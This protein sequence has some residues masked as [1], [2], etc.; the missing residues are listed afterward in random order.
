MPMISKIR[1]VKAKDDLKSS[2]SG[3]INF[4]AT[5]LYFKDLNWYMMIE[6]NNEKV[7]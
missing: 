6:Q 4:M 5:D 2:S 7:I 1:N 3:V